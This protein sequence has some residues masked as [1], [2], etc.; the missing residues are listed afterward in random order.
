MKN[1]LTLR[2]IKEGDI[3]VELNAVLQK[4][5]GRSSKNKYG[6]PRTYFLLIEF[7]RLEISL[8]DDKA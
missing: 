1:I 6:K 4:Y 3:F 7:L 5:L 2:V 8:F